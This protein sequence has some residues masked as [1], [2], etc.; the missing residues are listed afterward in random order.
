MDNIDFVMKAKDSVSQLPL[1]DIKTLTQ[2]NRFN[3]RTKTQL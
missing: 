2:K 3:G 1:D